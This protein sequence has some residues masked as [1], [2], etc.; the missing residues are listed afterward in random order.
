MANRTFVS[1]G[2]T[3]LTSLALMATPG[4]VL[5]GHHLVDEAEATAD[6]LEDNVEH[7]EEL[8][9]D[10]YDEDRKEG[11]G[12]VEAAGNAYEAVLEAG[13]EKADD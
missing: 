7:S 13:R 9:E 10:T 4:A 3:L 11:E 1:A 5:A 12:T 2:T 8:L 6:E